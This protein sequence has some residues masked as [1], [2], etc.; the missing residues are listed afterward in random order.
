[1]GNPE[2]RFSHDEAHM[3]QC[4]NSFQRVKNKDADQIVWMRAFVV[5]MQQSAGSDPGFLERG[6]HM[7]KGVGFAWLILSIF[8]Y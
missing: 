1:M 4:Y 7:Y 8:Y 3:D 5:R 2:D 6:V